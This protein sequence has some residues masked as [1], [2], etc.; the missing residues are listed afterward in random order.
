MAS[1][2][3]GGDSMKYLVISGIDGSGKTT[4]IEKVREYF[5]NENIETFYI[6]LRFNHYFC[7]G[8]HALARIFKL[9][10]KKPSYRGEAWFHEFYRSKLFCAVYIRLTYL[11]TIIGILKLRFKLFRKRN[12]EYIICDRWVPDILVDLAVKTHRNDFLDTI[13]YQ[14]FMRLMPDS[15]RLFLILRHSDKLLE[16]RDENREDP[17]FLFRSQIY[18]E[19]AKKKEIH[20]IDNNGPIEMTVQSFLDLVADE[21]A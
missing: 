20:V 1:G 12:A 14:R 5:T 8:M 17:D 18:A 3:Q 2:S 10:V 19:L 15:V 7:K 6:W 16:C 13:W 9:S 4:V 21:K 11:D